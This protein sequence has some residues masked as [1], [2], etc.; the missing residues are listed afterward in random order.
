MLEHSAERPG[1]SASGGE[2]MAV[3]PLTVAERVMIAK[4]QLLRKSGFFEAA[5][6]P[7]GL[8][9]RVPCSMAL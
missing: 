7:S 2:P 4:L 3:I 1:Q 5:Q 8:T 6:P 9:G